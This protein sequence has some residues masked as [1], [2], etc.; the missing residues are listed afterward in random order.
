MRISGRDFG[1]VLLTIKGG[2]VVAADRPVSYMKNWP[3]ARVLKLAE[4]WSWKVDIYDAERPQLE[5]PPEPAS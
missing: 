2:E 1:P 3:V 4:R 5:R